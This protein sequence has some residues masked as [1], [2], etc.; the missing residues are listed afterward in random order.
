MLISMGAHMVMKETLMHKD[1]IRGRGFVKFISPIREV[2]V[3]REWSL[4][5][6]HKPIGFSIV[7]QE[8]YANMLGKKEKTCYVIGEWISFDKEAINKTFNMKEMKD[9]SKFKSQITMG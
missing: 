6:E 1:F 7:V 5:W 4:F 2:I 9:G 8:F 3:K